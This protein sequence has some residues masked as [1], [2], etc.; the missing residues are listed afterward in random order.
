MNVLLYTEESSTRWQ[1]HTERWKH[2][3]DCPI[4]LSC[5]NHV[6]GRGQLPCDILFLGE[7]PGPEEDDEGIPF[8]GR[9]G[10]VLTALIRQASTRLKISGLMYAEDRDALRYFISNTLACFPEDPSSDTFRKPETTELLRCKPRV[11]DLLEFAQPRGVVLLGKVAEGFYLKDINSLS[12]PCVGLYH[13]S[14]INRNGGTASLMFKRVRDSL[15]EF[16]S[17]LYERN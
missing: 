3:I 14:Y 5:Q 9:A 1:Q 4:G 12:I 11:L 17:G 13:P 10:K 8:I 2:C 16:I 6:L 15:T 7:A